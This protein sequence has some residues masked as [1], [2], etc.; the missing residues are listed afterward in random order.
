[1][2]LV[3]IPTSSLIFLCTHLS[4]ELLLWNLCP[5]GLVWKFVFLLVKGLKCMEKSWFVLDVYVIEEKFTSHYNIKIS[6]IDSHLLPVLF[7]F[8]KDIFL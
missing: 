1:M 3:S 6:C 2:F 4:V 8:Q 5:Y 7:A